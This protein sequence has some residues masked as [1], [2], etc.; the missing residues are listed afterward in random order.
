MIR[1][2]LD[3]GSTT[4]KS[5]VL[6]EDG[7]ILY[8]QYERHFSQITSKVNEMLSEI[9][10]LFPEEE[11]VRLCISG[12]AGM[13]L[14]QDL[15]ISFAQEVYATREAVNT[16]L[17]G[18]DVVI[19]LGGEDAKI[20]FL[21]GSMDVCMNGSCAGGTGAFIDQMATLLG[22]SQ[23]EMN[24]LAASHKKCTVLLRAAAYLLNP[25]FSRCS[26]RAR[27]RR[28]YRHRSLRRLPIR[29]LPG[30]PMDGKSKEMSFT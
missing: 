4:L 2:G 21:S 8:Q 18:T 26:I 16:L 28:M 24:A 23:D 27:P 25:T 22:I 13:G 12:S 30:S 11:S 7:E 20:L 6:N 9:R 15:N 29:R 19:E 17:P 1:I 5:V 14:A 10:K 3:V